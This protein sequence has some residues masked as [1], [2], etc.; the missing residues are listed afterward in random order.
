M[1]EFDRFTLAVVDNGYDERHASNGH[2]RFGVYLD[3]GAYQL[4]DSG[5]LPSRAEFAVFAWTVATSKMSPGYVR[6]RPDLL[7]VTAAQAED[8]PADLVLRI[9][10]PLPHGV[11]AT[12]P[13]GGRWLDWESDC[14][15]GPWSAKVEPVPDRRPV[16]TLTADILL[17]LPAGELLPAP[18]S[19]PGPELTRA[20]K[21]AVARLAEHVNTH[22]GPA[23]DELLGGAR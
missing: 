4:D 21:R 6:V 10:A 9:T 8:D 11:L 23:V 13:G 12:R 7:A 2:S 15:P 14:Y 1:P 20:A 18:A 19:W 17:P 5:S 16:L 22:A 3:H